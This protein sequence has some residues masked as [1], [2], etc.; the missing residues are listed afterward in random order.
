MPNIT[1]RVSESAYRNARV[2]AAEHGES[3]SSIVQLCIENLP[4]MRVRRDGSIAIVTRRYK[5][6]FPP[7]RTME[8]VRRAQIELAEKTLAASKAQAHSARPANSATPLTPLAPL[9]PLLTV[10]C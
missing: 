6:V 7:L 2:W 3:L 5:P 4:N 10:H 1:V 9:A 8:D